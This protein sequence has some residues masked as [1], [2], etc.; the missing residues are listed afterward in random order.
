MISPAEMRRSSDLLA[1]G[2][3]IPEQYPLFEELAKPLRFVIKRHRASKQHTD[4][5]LEAFGEFLS[6]ASYRRPDLDPRRSI[7]LRE[8]GDHD[9]RYAESERRI[10]DGAYG[11]GPMIV[12]DYGTYR[13]LVRTERS[14]EQS[15]VSALQRG[16]L[17]FWMDG[18]RLKGGFRLDLTRKGWTLT[19]LADEFAAIR[20]DPWDDLSIITGRSLDD[21]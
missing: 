20:S 16:R 6:W 14:E 8:M 12:W 21:V 3:G 5:R 17:D 4:I 11:A 18:E 19:K 15:V 2:S 1:F 10:P 9:P 13:P 7:E